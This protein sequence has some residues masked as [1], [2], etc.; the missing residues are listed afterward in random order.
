MPHH[1][2]PNYTGNHDHQSGMNQHGYH[3]HQPRIDD[4]SYHNDDDTVRVEDFGHDDHDHHDH[5]DDHHRA[6]VIHLKQPKSHP[7]K[8]LKAHEKPETSAGKQSKDQEGSDN[9]C[10]EGGS[11]TVIEKQRTPRSSKPGFSENEVCLKTHTSEGFDIDNEP[12]RKDGLLWA[13]QIGH[14]PLTRYLVDRRT[15]IEAKGLE[16]WTPLH[17]AAFTANLALFR[18]LLSRGAKY[19]A[20]TNSDETTLHLASCYHKGHFNIRNTAHYIGSSCDREA[21]GLQLLNMGLFVDVENIW[22]ET[23]LLLATLCGLEN[24]IEVL[25]SKGAA[26][27]EGRVVKREKNLRDGTIAPRKYRP[28]RSITAAIQG[29]SPYVIQSTFPLPEDT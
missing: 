21:I 19:N 9:E 14:V 12:S 28:L 13:A 10:Q 18:L 26:A 6:H 2:Q 29:T 20:T 7:P 4:D 24:M 27:I 11:K 8:G 16:G 3:E 22:G 25:A 17:W 23:P 1:C 5:H 15:P